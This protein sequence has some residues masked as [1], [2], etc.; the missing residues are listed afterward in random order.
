MARNKPVSFPP[1]A[2]EL[3]SPVVDNHTHFPEQ[4]DDTVE[5]PDG[6]AS[7]P[8]DVQIERAQRAGIVG[9]IHSGCEYP[10]LEHAVELARDW[11]PIAAAIA[12]HPNEAPRHAGITE[13][14]PD[15]WEQELAPH[16][17]EVSLEDAIARVAEL[18]RANPE[19]VVAIGETG[20]DLY[21]T[22]AGG[23]EAQKRSFRE[24]IVLAKELGLPLQIHNREANA[25]VLEVLL[26]DG[27]P[28]RTV[29]HCFS[30]DAEFA[31]VLNEHG[32]YASF[33]GPITFRANEDLRAAAR[34]MD[35]DHVLVETDAPYLTPA[36][37]RGRPNAPYVMTHTVRAV[38]QEIGMEL[39]PACQ[40]I[41]ATT[42]R[43][44]GDGFTAA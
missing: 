39:T 7:L 40:T 2:D 26:R 19:Q 28:E 30:G 21:R 8:V 20:M 15:G 22:A 23:V 17:A 16:H 37:Y 12:I 18:A 36:P 13:T 5:L 4:G 1:E 25:E 14:A 10:G 27:A 33:A 41:L 34:A 3:P 32:W 11:A 6:V 24:H 29:F 31:K 44:Y 9:I 38:A 42:R 35:R 43:V